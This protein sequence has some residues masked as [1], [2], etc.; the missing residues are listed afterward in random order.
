MPSPNKRHRR[1]GSQSMS[2]SLDG[3]PGSVPA[4]VSSLKPEEFAALLLAEQADPNDE[5]TRDIVSDDT[6]EGPAGKRS[7]GMPDI[8]DAVAALCEKEERVKQ[9]AA[10]I[11][12][13]KAMLI[14][15]EAKEQQ[16]ARQ[17]EEAAKPE[18][19]HEAEKPQEEN[20]PRA[21]N[22]DGLSP[23]D[24]QEVELWELRHEVGRLS[25]REA[26]LAIEVDRLRG[27]EHELQGEEQPQNRRIR[28]TSQRGTFADE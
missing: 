27:R 10:E 26:Q 5:W 22:G 19:A 6:G 25:D 3:L 2:S 9:E 23:F 4:S 8:A 11:E 15:L 21:E 24:D 28:R 12:R 13:L 1:V 20:G 18:E 7:K 14:S 16:L 17:V